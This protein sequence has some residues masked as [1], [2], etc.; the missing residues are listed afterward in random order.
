MSMEVLIGSSMVMMWRGF[1]AL[2]LSIMEARVV[3]F[4][5]PV[6]PVTSTSPAAYRRGRSPH[7]AAPALRS[8]SSRRD[9]PEGSAHG[10]S[11]VET[12]ALNLAKP[13][14]PKE[15]SSSRSS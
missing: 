15:K 2:I 11:L 14:I 10:A 8:F 1:S 5:E 9:H 6:G 12:L 7:G 3:D 13:L 4:P